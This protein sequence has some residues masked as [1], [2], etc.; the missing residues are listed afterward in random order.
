M[1]AVSRTPLDQFINVRMRGYKEAALPDRL[2]RHETPLSPSTVARIDT[3]APAPR[4]VRDS[5]L[6]RIKG[7][8]CDQICAIA[9]AVAKDGV[10]WHCRF[11][12]SRVQSSDCLTNIIYLSAQTLNQRVLG[13]SPSA[14]TISSR[15]YNDFAGDGERELPDASTLG[16]SLGSRVKVR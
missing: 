3:P 11:R 6:T 7:E 1:R 4:W 14:S 16:S 15:H 8:R 10:R 2:D 12:G 9:L 13:S 5:R